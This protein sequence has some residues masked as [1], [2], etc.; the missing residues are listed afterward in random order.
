MNEQQQERVNVLLD[1]C[2]RLGSL[3]YPTDAERRIHFLCETAYLVST[4]CLSGD[5]EYMESVISFAEVAV[6]KGNS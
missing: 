5:E 1:V 4:S 3:E 2:K 6:K